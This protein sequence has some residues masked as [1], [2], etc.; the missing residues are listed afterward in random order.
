MKKNELK[1]NVDDVIGKRLGK[2]EVIS[3]AGFKLQMS[4]KVRKIRHYYLVKCDCGNTN[5]IRR[6][7][8][9]SGNTKKLWMCK[10]RWI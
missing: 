6:C 10:E 2:L 5:I 7:Q 1:V 8:I 4:G 3:Y 9:M